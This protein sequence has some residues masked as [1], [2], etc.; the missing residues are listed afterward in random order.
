MCLAQ[1]PQRSDAGEARTHSL[2]VSSQALYPVLSGHWKI[3][4]IKVLKTGVSL[5][6][7]KIIA[8]CS[9][10]S[11]LQYFQPAVSYN[12][13]WKPIL[14]SFWVAAYRRQV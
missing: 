2:S 10:W 14:V 13:S 5:M 4:K 9:L 3:D 12:W 1:G 6:Q 7:I 8:E 11:I